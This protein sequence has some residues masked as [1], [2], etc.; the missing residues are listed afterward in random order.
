MMID[1]FRRMPPHQ[2]LQK[3]DDLTRGIQEMALIGLRSRH[4][5]ADE[6]E[7][8]M[9]LAALWIDRETLQKAYGWSPEAGG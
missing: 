5:E 4:P 2:K 8:R 3:I 6:A 9:R 1:A 7:L